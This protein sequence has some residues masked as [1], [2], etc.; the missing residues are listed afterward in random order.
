LNSPAIQIHSPN[1]ADKT[2]LDFAASVTSAYRLST[3]KITTLD[4]KYGIP[5]LGISPKSIIKLRK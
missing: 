5:D 4:R 1:E 3:R 2:A